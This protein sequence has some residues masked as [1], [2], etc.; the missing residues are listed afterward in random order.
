MSRSLSRKRLNSSCRIAMLRK[1]MPDPLSL[2]ITLRQKMTLR[3][4]LSK[5]WQSILGIS[6][7]GV[8]DSFTELGGNSLLAVQVVSTVSGIFEIDIR[9]DSVY[10]NQT[11]QGLAALILTELETLL[12]E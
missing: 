10:Q 6:G 7:I 3:K 12:Q 4:R 11:V 2:W 1:G 8:N 9:V 5:V